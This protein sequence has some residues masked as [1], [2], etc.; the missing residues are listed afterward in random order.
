MKRGLSLVKGVLQA[1]L[2]PMRLG[3]KILW[4]S[5]Q[6]NWLS[7]KELFQSPPARNCSPSSTSRI[8][9]AST[10]PYIV[11]ADDGV[12][13][14]KCSS[15]LEV[16]DGFR[17]SADGP[18]Q[19]AQVAMSQSSAQGVANAN[20]ALLPQNPSEFDRTRFTGPDLG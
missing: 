1:G 9:M 12:L 20:A 11:D 7:K 4:K 16:P 8:G 10:H 15:L 2:A 13:R 17:L 5:V 6:D 18:R 19:L 3:S 14:L